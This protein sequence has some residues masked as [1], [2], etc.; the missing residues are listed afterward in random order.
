MNSKGLK[1]I[2][3]SIRVD[4]ND[5]TLNTFYRVNNKKRWSR[6]FKVH[7]VERYIDLHYNYVSFF[8]LT[9]PQRNTRAWLTEAYLDL[10]QKEGMTK[11]DNKQYD[12]AVFNQVIDRANA[13]KNAIK[14]IPKKD[15]GAVL[16]L[17]KML[18]RRSET[19]EK[20]YFD[21]HKG[22]NNVQEYLIEGGSTSKKPSFESI[23]SIRL[24][25]AKLERLEARQSQIYNKFVKIHESIAKK[26]DVSQVGN[27][28]AE[29]REQL[30]TISNNLNEEA[31][32]KLFIKSEEIVKVFQSI[33]DHD[34]IWNV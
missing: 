5:N 30:K 7:H 24:I 17:E 26:K 1:E 3:L 14:D 6:C 25:Q 13:V 23:Q 21:F 29:M 31:L 19:V 20:F 2:T 4:T 28:F 10:Q 12:K 32:N 18:A 34:T 8:S 16:Q 22:M 33:S 11:E 9:P 27:R 15:V